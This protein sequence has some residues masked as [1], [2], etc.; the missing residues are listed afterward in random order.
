MMFGSSPSAGKVLRLSDQLAEVRPETA[1]MV[2]SAPGVGVVDPTI[3]LFS[4]IGQRNLKRRPAP[5]L[6]LIGDRAVM[7]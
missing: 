1:W 2:A 5:R 4:D 7:R 3:A 6:T